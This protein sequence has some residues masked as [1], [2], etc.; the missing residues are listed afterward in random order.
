M[1][2]SFYTSSNKDFLLAHGDTFKLLTEFDFKFDMIFADPPYFLSNGGISMQSGKVVCVD[3]GKWDKGGTPEQMAEFNLK[4]ISLCKDKL[5][6]NGTIWISGTYHNIFSVANCLT[7]LGFKIL[8]VI[9][10]AKTNPPPNISCRYFTFSSEFIIWARKSPKIPHYYNYALMKKLNDNKQMADVWRLPSIAR[11]EKSC[12]KH[13]TQKPLSVLSR[14]IM[15]STRPG[16]WILDP[17]SGSCTTGV[18]ASLLRRRFVGIEQELEFLNMGKARRI[19]LD[20]SETYSTYRSKIK[21][22]HLLDTSEEIVAENIV[23]NNYD[24]PF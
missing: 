23:F 15:A 13:P 7:E 11:W 2:K 6:D 14:I 10:W 24:L 4:W 12:G 21:D 9:T 3:K 22:I 16:D 19:E 1:I 20:N 17:F 8:N 18:A 5:K